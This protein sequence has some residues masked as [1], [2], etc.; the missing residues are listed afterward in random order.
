MKVH[1]PM[2]IDDYRSRVSLAHLNIEYLKS[3]ALV[4]ERVAGRRKVSS[5]FAY[6]NLLI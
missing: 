1:A 4:I 6:K 3:F 2:Y 5:L